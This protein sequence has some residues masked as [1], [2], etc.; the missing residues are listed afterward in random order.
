MRFV[1][2]EKGGKTKIERILI[3]RG[4]QRWK[5]LQEKKNEKLR[6]EKKTERGERKR[7]GKKK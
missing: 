7:G 6:E 5:A 2:G 4:N 3:C 1:N